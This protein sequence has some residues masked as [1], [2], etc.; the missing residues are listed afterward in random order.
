MQNLKVEF[1]VGSGYYGVRCENVH[2]IIMPK[3]PNIVTCCDRDAPSGY[4][5]VTLSAGDAVQVV[6]DVAAAASSSSVFPSQ[7]LLTI[8][9]PPAA[10]GN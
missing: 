3:A 2:V 6:S 10:L 4:C 8:I 9:M 7:Q 5:T 1:Q